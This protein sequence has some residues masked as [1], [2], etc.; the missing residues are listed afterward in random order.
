MTKRLSKIALAAAVALVCFGVRAQESKPESASRQVHSDLPLLLALP[1]AK[2]TL[3][4]RLM[5]RRRRWL[6][7]VLI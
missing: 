6:R 5:A 4:W 1:A 2:L 7:S 3:L